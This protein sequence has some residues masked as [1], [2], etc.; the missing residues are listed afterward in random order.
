MT[1]RQ[2]LDA[3]LAAHRTV[4]L[5][6]GEGILDGVRAWRDGEDAWYVSY[7]LCELDTKSSPDPEFSGWGF[8]LVLRLRDA[9]DLPGW[10]VAL[11]AQIASYVAENRRPLAPGEHLLVRSLLA[12]HLPGFMAMIVET[13]PDLGGIDSDF[14]RIELLRLVPLLEPELLAIREGRLAEVVHKL[15]QLDPPFVARERAAV[16][17]AR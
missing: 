17:E 10:P 6:D 3:A 2:A 12:P 8:E 9:E 13:D 16:V 7:G 1:S 11:M 5:P 4:V 15:R 14:G